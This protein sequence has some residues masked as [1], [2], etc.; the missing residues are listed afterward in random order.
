MTSGG[1]QY[2]P[3]K[4]RPEGRGLFGFHKQKMVV[5]HTLTTTTGAKHGAWQGDWFWCALAVGF[6]DDFVSHEIFQL[7][8]YSL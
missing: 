3:N 8:S 6:G 2:P 4:K 7:K 1:F 5:T